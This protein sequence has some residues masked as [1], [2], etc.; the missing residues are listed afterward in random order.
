MYQR[1]LWLLALL[2]L[3]M[4]A[5]I[6]AQ[7]QMAGPD[8]RIGALPVLNMLPLYVAHDAGY[9]DE[10]GVV[11]EIVDFLSSQA[12]QEAAIA[13][14]IDGFQADLVSALVVNEQGGNLRVVRHVGITNIPFVAI[15]AGTG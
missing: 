4:A 2:L 6:T 3:L 11:V 15:I 1:I 13:G 8:L 9:F 7:D 14:E 5:P 10:A 12:A